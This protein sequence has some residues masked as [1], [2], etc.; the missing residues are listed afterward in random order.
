MVADG[1]PLW[2]TA[3]GAVD[4][5]AVSSVLDTSCPQVCDMQVGGT[6]AEV[7]DVSSV[8][9]FQSAQLQVSS[10]VPLCAQ[11]DRM[12]HGDL[13]RLP[14]RV[15]VP[16]GMLSVDETPSAASVEWLASLNAEAQ[17]TVDVRSTNGRG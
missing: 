7:E 8:D 5:G 6:V 2:P 13:R 10:G 3:L 16:H 17:T 12:W 4:D 1:T 15:D 11:V 9:Q 14:G